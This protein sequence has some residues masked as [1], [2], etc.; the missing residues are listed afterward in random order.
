MCGK[1]AY[2]WS[3]RGED[4]AGRIAKTRDR[5]VEM[6]EGLIYSRGACSGPRV[7]AAMDIAIPVRITP[8][9]VATYTTF[10]ALAF[11]GLEAL[12]D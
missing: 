1:D 10:N 8:S 3:G 7:Q 6:K 9:T 12:R 5:D 4:M 11:H 2:S